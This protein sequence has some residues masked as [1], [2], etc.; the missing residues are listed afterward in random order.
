MINCLLCCTEIKQSVS[1]YD[2]FSL[3]SKSQS[4]TTCQK[5]LNKFTRITETKCPQCSRQ[6]EQS[7]IC[8]DCERWK[9][10]YFGNVLK[11]SSL[12]IYDDLMHDLI[13]SYKKLGDYALSDVFSQLIK[14]EFKTLDYDFYV[15]LP[16]DPKHLETRK[17]D[18][19]TAIFGNLVSLTPILLKKETEIAQSQKNR[20]ERMQTS[21]S[22]FINNDFANFTLSGKI[23]LLDDL[24]TTGRTLYHAR[25]VLQK[26]F[27][28]CTYESFSVIR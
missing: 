26:K 12:F 8:E 21:Q 13:H 7:V 3:Q 19:V 9:Q 17:F 24:Y 1:L 18:T 28:N 27:P 23:L 10:K 14:N 16:T 5:C 11:N 20:K 25:D 22:F 15:P 2:I 4:A 6:Q